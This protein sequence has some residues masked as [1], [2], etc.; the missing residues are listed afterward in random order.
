MRFIYIFLSLIAA[1]LTLLVI[2][3]TLLVLIYGRFNLLLPGLG[4]VIDGWSVIVSLAIVDAVI[5]S[6]ALIAK[7]LSAGSYK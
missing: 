7:K 1:L 4:L 3:L 2:G 6:L 5:I